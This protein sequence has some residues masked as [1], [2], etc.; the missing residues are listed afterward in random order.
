MQNGFPI[1]AAFIFAV[2]IAG[3]AFM[4]MVI[5]YGMNAHSSPHTNGSVRP[6]S[7]DAARISDL[8]DAVAL[9]SL[10]LFGL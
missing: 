4:N 5:L 1:L 9:I 10:E 2:L 7:K 6:R 3:T 8:A